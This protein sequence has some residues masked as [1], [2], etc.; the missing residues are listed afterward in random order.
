MRPRTVSGTAVKRGDR[1]VPMALQM[2]SA[3]SVAWPLSAAPLET[4]RDSADSSDSGRIAPRMI[5][6]KRS[7]GL[8]DLMTSTTAVSGAARSTIPWIRIERSDVAT[9]TPSEDRAMTTPGAATTG[10][11]GDPVMRVT[12]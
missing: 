5:Q 12:E 2:G 1:S 6:T 3:R 7:P 9:S 4:T 11:P 8:M 10:P